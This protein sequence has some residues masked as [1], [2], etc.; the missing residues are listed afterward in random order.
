MGGSET[1][2]G[3]N[4]SNFSTDGSVIVWQLVCARSGKVKHTDEP[5]GELG[6]ISDIPPLQKDVVFRDKQVT[7]EYGMNR[8]WPS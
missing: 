2:Q 8:G 3:Q 4:Q 5:L 7:V 1:S 6:G